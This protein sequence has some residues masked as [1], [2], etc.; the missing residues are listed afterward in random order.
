[1]YLLLKFPPR[2]R[3]HHTKYTHG[4]LQNGWVSVLGTQME[5]NQEEVCS[6]P[7]MCTSFFFAGDG[8]QPQ[9]VRFI[10][11][12][13]SLLLSGVHIFLLGHL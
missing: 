9:N 3:P 2:T 4:Y 1:M 12:G 7:K 11:P 10:K 8:A 13:R 6:Y 5:L